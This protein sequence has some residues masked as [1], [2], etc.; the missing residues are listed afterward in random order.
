LAGILGIFMRFNIINKKTQRVNEICD[1]ILE[2]ACSRYKEIIG[3]V[4]SCLIKNNVCWRVVKQGCIRSKTEWT[5]QNNVLKPEIELCVSNF[6]GKSVLWDL[7]HELGHL[8][9]LDFGRKVPIPIPWWL[10]WLPKQECA[11]NKEEAQ[12]QLG[13]EKAAWDAAERWLREKLSLKEDELDDFNARRE[14]CLDSYREKV[15]DFE[16]K[17]TNGS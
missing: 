16:N 8:L 13:N 9:I 11:Q 2:L 4:Y 1:P 14:L 12:L 6:L 17:V 10:S 5:H 15:K 7:V 3:E